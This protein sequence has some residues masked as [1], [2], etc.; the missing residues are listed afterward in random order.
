MQTSLK[1]TT[2]LKTYETPKLVRRALQETF[3]L[4]ECTIKNLNVH[5]I[6]RMEQIT[7]EIHVNYI[8]N[9]FIKYMQVTCIRKLSYFLK[10]ALL[11]LLRLVFLLK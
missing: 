1:L 6:A 3:F 10:N 4:K 2:F 7:L 9:T 5:C 11:G 8:Q